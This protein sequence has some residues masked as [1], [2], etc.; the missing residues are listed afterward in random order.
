MGW[1]RISQY[2]I[3]MTL[4]IKDF[5]KN[6][7]GTYMCVAANTVGRA[8]G[9]IR[10]YGKFNPNTYRFTNFSLQ[11]PK[12]K[13]KLFLLLHLK[14]GCYQKI[15]YEFLNP[16]KFSILQLCSTQAPITRIQFQEL[17]AV[18]LHKFKT[19]N[20]KPYY[21]FHSYSLDFSHISSVTRNGLFQ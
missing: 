14:H 18:W 6:D 19:F 17:I 4:V 7:L 9:T 1:E 5:G 12:T 10:L 13:K 15:S 11:M 8:D 20:E 2:E 21:I 3:R 16:R